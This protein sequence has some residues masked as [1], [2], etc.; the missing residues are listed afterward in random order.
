MCWTPILYLHF[1]VLICISGIICYWWSP[2]PHS[3]FAFCLYFSF[4]LIVPGGEDHWCFSSFSWAMRHSYI[5]API[6]HSCVYYLLIFLL[7]WLDGRLIVCML[8]SLYFISFSDSAF[9]TGYV[10]MYL[11]LSSCVFIGHVFYYLI[12]Y[13]DARTIYDGCDVYWPFACWFSLIAYVDGLFNWVIG[14]MK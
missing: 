12:S 6:D 14:I 2:T 9:Q 1:G 13:V 10:G 11:A 4:W 8:S 5:C 3:E 7:V